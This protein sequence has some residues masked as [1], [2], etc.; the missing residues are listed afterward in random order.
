MSEIV[1]DEAGVEVGGHADQNLTEGE[2]WIQPQETTPAPQDPPAAERPDF[3]PEKFWTGD[4]A[5][6]SKKMA[7]SYAKLEAARGKPPT[8]TESVD[9]DTDGAD[10]EPA[11]EADQ[12]S[13]IDNAMAAFE[14]DGE[15][16]DEHYESLAAAGIAR[17]TVDAYIQ[18]QQA[19]TLLAHTAAGGAEEYAAMT[20]WAAKALTPAEVAEFNAAVA[21]PSNEMVAAIQGL[22]SRYEAQSST[23][24]P[25]ESGQR[26]PGGNAGFASKAEMTAAMSDPRY[27]TDPAYRAEVERKLIAGSNAGVNL[28]Q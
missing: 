23:E 17:E 1:A 25:L 22:R 10:A 21:A 28:W 2:E 15:L 18:N 3:I 24:P 4:L 9:T 11:S 12:Q 5:E 13:A 7:E 19:A 6:S 16:A 27:K 26:A 8:D 20:A 14:A